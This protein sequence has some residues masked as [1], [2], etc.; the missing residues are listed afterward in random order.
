MQLFSLFREKIKLHSKK[1]RLIGMI[2]RLGLNA[3]YLKELKTLLKKEQWI[4]KSLKK[5]VKKLS[6]FINL[7]LISEQIT[8]INDTTKKQLD[9][10]T[11]IRFKIFKQVNYDAFKE[12]CRKEVE[13][14]KFFSKIIGETVTNIQGAE[15]PKEEFREGRLLVRQAQKTYAELLNAVGNVKKVQQKAKEL[16]LINRKIKKTKLYGFIKYDVDFVTGKAK[17]ALKNPKESKL[18]FFLAGAYI[19]S[20]GTFELTGIYLFFR[21]L[22]KYVK[23][24]RSRISG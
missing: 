19:V 11:R 13:Q 2:D 12:A 7:D 16:I 15:I 18:K 6:R 3:V 8:N 20:P 22:T 10:L 5:E 23:D 4:N 9:I 21:Y 17:Y 24:K 1:Y 14:S